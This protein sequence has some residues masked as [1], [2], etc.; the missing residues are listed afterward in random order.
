MIKND[1]VQL[2]IGTLLSYAQMG[3]SVIIGLIYTP[4]MI[5]LLG[6]SEYGLYNTVS[7]TI[8]MMSV[9]SLG[10]NSSYIR[11]YS[12]YKAEGDSKKLNK[13]NG[14]FLLI[15]LVIGSIAFLC[16]MFLSQNLHI[17]FDSGLTHAEYK[18][19]KI[20]MYILTI[21]L[22]VSFPMLA[23]SSIISAHEKY[24]ILKLIGILKTV[25][26]PLVTLPL[27]LMGYRSIAMVSV[28]VSLSLIADVIYLVYV[29]VILKC[30]FSFGKVD[31]GLAKELSAY[32]LFIAIELVVDQI[33]WNVDKIL[34]ARFRGTNSVAIYSVGY[35]L[36]SYYQL[37][38][39][40][41]SGVFT[42]RIHKI[43]NST[44]HD[45]RL[46]REKLTELFIK[47]GRIQFLVLALL[48]SGI[49]FFGKS[50]IVSIWAGTGYDEAYYVALLLILPAS[51]ALV[52]NLGIEI[53]RAKNIHHFRSIVYAFMAMINVVVSYILCQKYGA[54]GSAFGTAVSLILANGLVMN[55]FYHK[56]CNIDI[57]L[58]W[59]N[60]L[61][62][63][64]GFLPCFAVGWLLR[65]FIT[66]SNI[67]DF[68]VCVLIY[69]L[70]Y[71]ISAWLLCMNDF[72]KR[73]ISA[74]IKKFFIDGEDKK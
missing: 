52:Q 38:S 67:G 3:L 49:I 41:I 10:F 54:T 64:V 48:A 44:I 32:T 69:T 7:S 35:S 65:E 42:P 28:T 43:V 60:I 57:I 40:S 1:S 34:L 16:G 59:K 68:A 55:I 19:A 51:I 61:R 47:V 12:K 22:A 26:G 11:F 45:G 27:L 50:F 9:L 5:R 23:F 30:K 8:S 15:F 63:L 39:S 56:R 72:E 20:L 31:E 21:N 58:F 2:K 37:C 33:N 25:G 13:L 46:Q 71:F 6:K 14:L 17:V 66:I 74:P 36:Y 18:T 29:L 4:V 73:L 70:I 53:Q 62:I 24:I